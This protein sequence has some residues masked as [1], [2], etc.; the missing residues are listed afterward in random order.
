MRRVPQG[1]RIKGNQ[2]W[3]QKLVLP[4]TDAIAWLSLLAE[5]RYAEYRDQAFLE[6][7]NIELPNVS[8]SH[9]WPSKSG[10]QRSVQPVY[11]PHVILSATK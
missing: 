2:K 9:F 6:L 10:S 5:D 7:V 8:P 11:I 1:P 4:N 3:I